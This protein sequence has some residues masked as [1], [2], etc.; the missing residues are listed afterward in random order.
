M[1]KD[2]F[3]RGGADAYTAPQL[4]L[5]EIEA[6]QGFAASDVWGDGNLDDEEN[7]LGCY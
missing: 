3:S 1:K 2:L 4:E 7:D 5:L 6:E